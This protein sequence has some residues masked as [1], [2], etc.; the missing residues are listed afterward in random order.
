[1]NTLKKLYYRSLLLWLKVRKTYYNSPLYTIERYVR[2]LGNT[3]SWLVWIIMRALWYLMSREFQEATAC[4]EQDTRDA[5]NSSLKE[6]IDQLHM[7]I[8]N[9][10]S[11]LADLKNASP[12]VRAAIDVP[13]KI[14]MC[15][16]HISDCETEIRDLWAKVK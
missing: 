16:D 11:L 2:A 4:I 10:Y 12:E 5:Y 8:D 9:A 15:R 1:M 14:Q 13:A 6:R 3:F 7:F